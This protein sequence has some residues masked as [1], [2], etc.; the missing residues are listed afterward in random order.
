MT[1]T[2]EPAAP[3]DVDP[4]HRVTISRVIRSEWS[5]LWSLRS[6]WAT[7]GIALLFLVGLGT[8]AAALYS[9]TGPMGSDHSGGAAVTLA[10]SGTNLAALAVGALGVLL[11]AGEYGTGMVRSTF[12]AVPKRLPVLWAK[13]LVLG[14]TAFLSCTVAAVASFLF[15][16][17]I[18]HGQAIAV[19]LGHADVL[20]CLVGAGFYLGFV[21]VL[22]VTVGM[23][24]RNS[25]AGIAILAGVVLVLPGLTGLLPGSW[26]DTVNRF[27]PSS[28]GQSLTSATQPAHLFGPAAGL[29][30]LVGWAIVLLAGAAYR[31]RRTDV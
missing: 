31:L 29:F 5:K 27:L 19:S 6:S 26:S 20:R 22:G 28:A 16:S 7:L 24:V 9:P 2:V 3:T 11:S 8:V 10:L 30:V 18:L 17:A 12:A 13:S 4:V 1:T 25:A 23:L 21:A 15:G 14:P